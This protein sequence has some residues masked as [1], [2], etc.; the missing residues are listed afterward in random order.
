MIFFDVAVSV[1]LHISRA[2][3]R[4][5]ADES[6]YVFNQPPGHQTTPPVIVGRL[7]TDTVESLRLFSFLSKIENFRR[8]SLHSEGQFVRLQPSFQFV[9]AGL[10]SCLV[11][12]SDE[13]Q[14]SLALLQIDVRWQVE[15]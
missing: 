7:L 15:I 9:V 1:P 13:L 4:D 10:Q 12:F 2:A 6:D 3:S 5:N 8:A 14:C 11:Q